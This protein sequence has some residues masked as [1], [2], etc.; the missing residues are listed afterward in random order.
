MNDNWEK[1]GLKLF[2]R[3]FGEDLSFEQLE[4]NLEENPNRELILPLF[5]NLKNNSKL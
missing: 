4:N 1:E 2:K 5:K 3:I